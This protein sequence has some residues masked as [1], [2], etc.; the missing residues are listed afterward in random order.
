MDIPDLSQ[1]LLG[2]PVEPAIELTELP[3]GTNNRV[4]LVKT[5]NG[6][7]YV[8]RLTA[9]SGPDDL[10]RFGYETALLA[11]LREKALPFSLPVPLQNHSGETLVLLEQECSAPLIATLCPFLAGT[12]SER[13]AT[14]VAKVAVALAQLDTV[15]AAIPGNSLPEDGDTQHFQYGSLY[16]CHPL[17]PDPLSAVERLLEPAQARPLCQIIRRAQEDWEEL[18]T[19]GLPQ[20]ILHRDCGPGNVLMDQ[21]RVTAILDFEFAGLD[22]RVFDL[23]VALSWWPVRMMG[24]GQEWELIDAFGQAYTT[25]LPLSEEEF[26]VLPSALRMRDITSLIYRIGRYL[27]GLET[28]ETVQK[29]VQHSLWR[30]AWLVANGETLVKH[31][32]TWNTLTRSSFPILQH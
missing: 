21:N 1:L 22:H 26:R 2:W 10:A 19:W 14:D 13:T 7:A 6:S 18:C 30:E 12:L 5:G 27:A 9:S 32:M 16:H 4:W 15:L 20:Q 31:G 24:T 3:G 25:C 23:C 17:V 8:L 29:R 28:K 11:A